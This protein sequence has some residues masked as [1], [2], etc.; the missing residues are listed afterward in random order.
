VADLAVSVEKFEYFKD[1]DRSLET[2]WVRFLSDGTFPDSLRP[3]IAKSW[4]RCLTNHIDPLKRRA[5]IVCM[6]ENLKARREINQVLLE[7]A[8]PW[9]DEMYQCYSNQ[10][11]SVVVCDSHG[12]ILDG[13]ATTGTWAKLERN[14]FVP[15]ADWSE[16]RAGTNAIGTALTEQKPVQVFSAEHF[17]QGWHPWV[18]SAAPVK[19]PVT[20][21]LLG[22]LDVTGKKSLVQAHDL[23]MVMMQ[24]KKIEQTIYE[25]LIQQNFELIKLLFDIIQDPV[26]IFNSQGTIVKCNLPASYLLRVQSGGTLK[27]VIHVPQ[28]PELLKNLKDKPVYGY[29]RS[30]DGCEWRIE[31]RPY[32]YADRLLG[33]LALFKKVP[34][35]V[36]ARKSQKGAASTRYTF[37][38]FITAD[39]SLGRILEFAERIAASDATVLITG[40]TGTGKEMLAQSIHACSYRSDGPFIGVNC[41]AI[42]KELMASELFGYEGG[43]FTGAKPGGKKGWVTLAEGGTL[44]LDEIGDLPLEAQVFLLRMLEEREVYPIGSTRPVSVNVRIIAATHRDLRHEVRR[45]RF[46]E[47]LYYR[48]QVVHLGLPPLRERKQD[49]PLLVEHFLRTSPHGGPGAMVDPEA[50][51]MM[52]N[53]TWPGNVRQLRN[54]VE[55]ALLS[56]LDGKIKVENLPDE[57]RAFHPVSRKAR[58]RA[59][60]THGLSRGYY[61]CRQTRGKVDKDA[62]IRALEEA[63]GNVSKASRTLRVSRMTIYRKLKEF[64][65]TLGH[66]NT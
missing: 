15:G 2:K 33:G 46:R 61:I 38:D 51:E 25:K 21:T 29:Y 42:P 34:S 3:V 6:D 24:A 39:S 1:I 18:C 31:V 9:M 40:E 22:V 10:T 12:V 58:P 53:Y 56:S 64:G 28:L 23:H 26:V 47:D 20:R 14:N 11:I 52:M 43:A 8:L 13:R 63:G 16:K 32:R 49:I 35:S 59:R 36:P 7:A 55:Q 30:A 54:C 37:A 48:L 19:D 17:C 57:I 27:H 45:G 60:E 4:E 44:F 5:D 41:G 62:L 65:I 66:D 50:L